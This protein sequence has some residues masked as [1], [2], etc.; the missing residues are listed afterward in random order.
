MTDFNFI[1]KVSK[2]NQESQLLKFILFAKHLK[3][4]T[5]IILIIS[6]FLFYY[7]LITPNIG[8]P[9]FRL[10]E[11]HFDSQ[12]TSNVFKIRIIFMLRKSVMSCGYV[13]CN[14]FRA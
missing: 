2:K 12:G 9:S 4:K 3:I 5:I 7:A 10:L 1:K 6:S 13:F 14:F 11:F 8:I